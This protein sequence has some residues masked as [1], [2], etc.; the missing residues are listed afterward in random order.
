[1]IQRV[2]V[3][4]PERDVEKLLESVLSPLRFAEI[5]LGSGTAYSRPG[6]ATMTRIHNRLAFSAH[7]SA[8]RV[9]V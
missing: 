5:A 1:M 7:F 4:I 3:G 9:E 6:P 2:D 8:V